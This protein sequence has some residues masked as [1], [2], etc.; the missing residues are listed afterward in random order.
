MS[1]IEH[2]G[3][4]A[5]IAAYCRE[6]KLPTVARECEQRAAEV[7]R[8]KADALV[9]V[10][11]LLAAEHD[12]RSRRRT[13]RRLKEAHFPQVKSIDGFDFRRNPA[14]DETRL[15]ELLELEFVTAGRP[16]LFLGGTG[17]GKTHL[18]TALGYAAC[19]RGMAVKFITAA[20]LVN[21]LTEAADTRALSRV[22]GRYARVELLVLDELGYVPLSP[23]A[24]QLLFQVVAERG[25]RRSTVVTTNLPFGEWT[26]ILPDPRLCR[27]FV[28]RMT[29]RAHIIET[30]DQSVRLEEMLTL[31]R[32]GRKDARRELEVPK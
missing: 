6:M 25:E 11:S 17:T 3:L 30:G 27:A 14:L 5:E 23:V 19:T 4:L 31:A 12:E 2:A 8:A 16:V 24:S 15:R 10:E 1:N 20:A 26:A 21:E 9:L 7:R 28:E 29:Y 32:K 22:V 13:Q 18:A